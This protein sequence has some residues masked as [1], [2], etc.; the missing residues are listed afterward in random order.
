MP[1]SGA[2]FNQLHAVSQLLG[3]VLVNGTGVSLLVFEA[4]LLEEVQQDS[5]FHF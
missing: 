1:L 2:D 3:D 5:R 4:H